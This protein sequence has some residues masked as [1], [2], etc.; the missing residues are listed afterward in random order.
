MTKPKNNPQNRKDTTF[1]TPYEEKIY[2]LLC[3]GLT[4]EEIADRIG[5]KV[6]SVKSRIP[7]IREKVALHDLNQK[8]ARYPVI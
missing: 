4:L 7:V 3:E 6:L 5:N 8:Q 2:N 1:L